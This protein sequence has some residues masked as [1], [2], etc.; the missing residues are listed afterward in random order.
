M[1]TLKDYLRDL[2]DEA[3]EIG[4]KGINK[5]P[6]EIEDEKE[7]LLEAYMKMIVER[8]IGVD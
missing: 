4:E 6:V 5:K 7:D 8:I 1:T 3:I 2:I